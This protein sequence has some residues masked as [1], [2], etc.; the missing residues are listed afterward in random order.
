MVRRLD[1]LGRIVIPI[2]FRKMNNW[3][4]KEQIE[5]IENGEELILRKY[6][7]VYCKKCNTSISKNDKYCRNCGKKV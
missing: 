5:M 2:E 6:N 1:E 4:E 7:G 3:K